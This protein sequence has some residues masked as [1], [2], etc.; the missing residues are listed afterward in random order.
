MPGVSTLGP[1]KKIKKMKKITILI[2]FSFSLCSCFQNYLKYSRI[3]EWDYEEMKDLYG[4]DVKF[5]VYYTNN[6]K[7]LSISELKSNHLSGTVERYEPAISNIDA[8]AKKRSGRILLSIGGNSIR[9]EAHIFIR[10][11]FSDQ[12]TVL[13]DR[14]NFLEMRVYKVRAYSGTMFF[15]GLSAGILLLILV[16]VGA[17]TYSAYIKETLRLHL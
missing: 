11:E 14:N 3:Q 6:L 12:K 10:D 1:F 4:S 13:I 9:S 15:I 17:K 7:N 16:V 2:V 5:L 8:T